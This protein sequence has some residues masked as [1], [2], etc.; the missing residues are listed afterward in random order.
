MLRC[1]YDGDTDSA[2]LYHG[3]FLVRLGSEYCPTDTVLKISDLPKVLLDHDDFQGVFITNNRDLMG[4]GEGFYALCLGSNYG[5]PNEKWRYANMPGCGF[6]WHP[7]RHVGYIKTKP[8]RRD[9]TQLPW[10][11][12]VDD[13]GYT[14]FDYRSVVQLPCVSHLQKAP[15]S[16]YKELLLSG[17]DF[18]YMTDAG[19]RFMKLGDV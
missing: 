2:G 6:T 14:S 11:L 17:A 8:A 4:V 1:S 10:H 3:D 12:Y 16:L 5:Q 13:G 9:I 19:P 7:R 15:P 18:V